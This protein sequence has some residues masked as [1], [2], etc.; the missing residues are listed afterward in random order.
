MEI[1]WH[2]SSY[3]RYSTTNPPFSSGRFSPTNPSF[4]YDYS[5]IFPISPSFAPLSPSLLNSNILTTISAAIP[6]GNPSFQTLELDHYQGPARSQELVHTQAPGIFLRNA[7]LESSLETI[8]LLPA[9]RQS[10]FADNGR[11]PTS[12]NLVHKGNT[13]SSGESSSSSPSYPVHQPNIGASHSVAPELPNSAQESP[14]L[15]D[16]REAPH[17]PIAPRRRRKS[18]HFSCGFCSETFTRRRDLK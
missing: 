2:L 15:N 12:Q 11:T 4:E 18:L 3:G 5:E 7:H 9:R 6:Q 16:S 14:V 17:N 8:C 13:T 1:P 10:S